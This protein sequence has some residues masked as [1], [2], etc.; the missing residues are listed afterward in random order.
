MF[1]AKYFMAMLKN[2][3]LN[4]KIIVFIFLIIGLAS[5]GGTLVSLYNL[6]F[7]INP[8]I[9]GI[10][11][12]YGLLKHRQ[13]WKKC[14]LFFIWIGMIAPV[15]ALVVLIVTLVVG[16]NI[17]FQYHYQ[18]V[19]LPK[20]IA[21]PLAIILTTSVFL[22]ALWQYKVLTN[23]KIKEMFMPNDKGI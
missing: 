14:A 18:L 6:P 23:P 11:I 7:T 20:A 13:G 21:A 12:C 22:L 5:L 3:P 4:L 19:A 8:G 2:N 10:P 1:A 17:A 9:L 16:G 15:F